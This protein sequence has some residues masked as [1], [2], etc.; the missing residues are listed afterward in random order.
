MA[1]NTTLSAAAAHGRRSADAGDPGSSCKGWAVRLP[2]HHGAVAEC[3]MAGGQ[4]SSAADLATRRAESAAEAAATRAVV[5][6]GWFVCAVAPRAGESCVA[7]RVARRLGSLQ[8]IET[9]ADVMLV[10][11][12][13]EHI[14]SDNGPEF[15]AEELRKWL[16]KVGTRTLY[17]EP[18]SPWENG[19]CESFNGKLR[20]EFLNGE[21]FYSLKEAQILTER[22]RVEYNTERPHSALG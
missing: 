13:P 20:D 2:A 11:G 9:L 1:R 12:I 22:W 16:G 17:I 7:L 14:R 6:R 3:G 5:A 4:G 10:R 19:Y 8:V 18:G 15:I 21:I